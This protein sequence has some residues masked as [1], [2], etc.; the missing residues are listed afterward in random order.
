MPLTSVDWPEQVSSQPEGIMFWM[1]DQ[2]EKPVRVLVT[3]QAL[4]HELD[5]Y[6]QPIEQFGGRK[7][8]REH[9]DRIEAAAS[10]K[11]DEKGLEAELEGK[12]ALWITSGDL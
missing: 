7:I 8:F 11:Y 12:P 1:K 4:H 2:D 5:N 10:K 3:K 9:R 6:Q